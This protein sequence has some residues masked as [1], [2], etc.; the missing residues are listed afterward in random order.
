M[1]DGWR[2]YQGDDSSHHHKVEV[3][4]YLGDNIPEEEVVVDHIPVVGN[5]LEGVELEHNHMEVH[6][7]IFN[8]N[9]NLKYLIYTLW[10]RRLIISL[11]RSRSWRRGITSLRRPMMDRGR[12]LMCRRLLSWRWRPRWGLIYK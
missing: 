11:W 8:E 12:L 3:E 9:E 7:L 4:Q 6:N 5:N 10:W 2:S 1:I